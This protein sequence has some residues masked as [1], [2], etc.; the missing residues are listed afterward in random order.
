MKLIAILLSI[1]MTGAPNSMTNQGSLFTSANVLNMYSA[2]IY[3][4]CPPILHW[5]CRV[6]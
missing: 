3:P 5:L 2:E 4:K 6:F 1:V